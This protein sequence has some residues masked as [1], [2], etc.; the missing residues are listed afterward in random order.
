MKTTINM[1]YKKKSKLI[2]AFHHFSFFVGFAFMITI[3]WPY[4]MVS[5]KF[6][7]PHKRGYHWR[8]WAARLIRLVL[9]LH[10]ID[11]KIKNPENTHDEGAAI[12]APNHGSELDGF[13]MLSI[14]GPKA[15]LVTMPFDHFPGIMKFWLKKMETIAVLRDPVDAATSK[16]ALPPRQAIAEAIR[17]L[18]HGYS[19]IIFPEGHIESYHELHYFHTGTA[20]ISLGSQ[21]PTIPVGIANTD[22]VIPESHIMWPGTVTITFGKKIKP[23]KEKLSLAQ[24]NPENVKMLRTLL[25]KEVIKLLPGRYVPKYYNSSNKHIGVFVDIDNT[26]YNGYSQQD[27]IKY[28]LW[29]HKI[30]AQDAFKIFY[31]LF[32]E[33]AG[34]L[35]HTDL[36][37]KAVWILH[38]WDVGELHHQIHKTFDEKLIKNIN[39]GLLPLIKDHTEAGHKVIFVSEVIH[40]LATEFRN[41][42]QAKATLDTMIEQKS[43]H[44]TGKVTRLCYCQEKANALEKFSTIKNIDLQHSFALADSAADIPF[45]QKVGN[46]MVVK[47][48]HELR[49]TAKTHHWKIL[50][51][52]S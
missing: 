4:L 26:I 19:L 8:N 51:D 36:M 16:E 9:F 10:E 31:W 1:L 28:L 6:L 48:G 40:P 29:L 27:L 35:R 47:P 20:R 22:V 34:R 44:Y 7:V 13:I 43:H 45:L 12:Y 17:T 21:T 49:E 32:L 2:G 37:K 41:L 25:E 52:V 3:F 30:K 39:Y 23:F 18:E 38:G 14:L 15:V 5:E 11:V 42:F 33:K 50:E 46:V 24:F